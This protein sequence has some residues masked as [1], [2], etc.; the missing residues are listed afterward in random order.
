MHKVQLLKM[1]VYFS[2]IDLQEF[3]ML[4]QRIGVGPQDPDY[5]IGES[6]GHPNP[7]LWQPSV[8]SAAG[9]KLV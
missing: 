1:A 7:S 4:L 9:L 3:F 2:L 5:P 6:P 8:R